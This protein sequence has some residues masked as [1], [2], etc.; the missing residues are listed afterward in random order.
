MCLEE[1]FL[2]VSKHKEGSSRILM[3]LETQPTPLTLHCFIS[4]S[5]TLYLLHVYTRIL[6]PYTQ[7]NTRSRKQKAESTDYRR[8]QE[9]HHTIRTCPFSNNH[10]FHHLSRWPSQRGLLESNWSVSSVMTSHC[11]PSLSTIRLRIISQLLESMLL[12]LSIQISWIID[13]A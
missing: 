11:H 4:N 10:H 13:P 5:R 7:K 1:T 3:G 6:Y 9:E 2:C 12:N 8:F